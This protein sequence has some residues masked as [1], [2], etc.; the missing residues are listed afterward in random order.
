MKIAEYALLAIALIAIVRAAYNYIQI[1]IP[2]EGFTS[3]NSHRRP[4]N[5]KKNSYKNNDMGASMGDDEDSTEEMMVNSE[6][7]KEYLDTETEDEPKDNDAMPT[8]ALEDIKKSNMNSDMAVKKVNELL[9]VDKKVAPFTNV[10]GQSGEIQSAFIP[11]I[12]I[13]Q[14]KNRGGFGS[15]STTS[16]THV[17]TNDGM[18]FNDTMNPTHNLWADD[19]TNYNGGN[20]NAN[21]WT[22]SMDAYNHGNLYKRPSDYIDY[23]SPAV[24]GTTTP[25]TGGSS[26]G[27]KKC[28]EYDNL[29]T[30]QAGNLVVR[31]YKLAKT[32]VPGYTYIPPA[33][34]DVPQKHIGHCLPNGPN[35]RKLTG[36]VDRGL[37][38]NV[39]ELNP[40]GEIADTEESVSLTNVGSIMPKFSYQEAPFSK[41]YV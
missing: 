19:H 8:M 29:D 4:R 6:D 38:L 10:D 41:P 12:N 11:Q 1:S 16:W 32:Y 26:T 33:N 3:S 20:G 7:S 40:N 28:G 37:P 2:E 27:G 39:L 23:T 9:G 22:Q 15:E 35:V 14:G 34:W 31:D 5:Q 24:Y 18:K 25:S 13:G 21:N 30:D 17:F 36:L